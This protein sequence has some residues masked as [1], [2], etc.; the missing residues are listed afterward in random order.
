MA[1]DRLACGTVGR[2]MSLETGVGQPCRHS[3]KRRAQPVKTL[4]PHPMGLGAHASCVLP[5]GGKT[6]CPSVRSSESRV[7]AKNV[8]RS[9]S[10]ITI[11]GGYKAACE[12]IS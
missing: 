7:R 8:I 5:V 12:N 4:N 6:V 3:G 9:A 1:Y 10:K 2:S 11:I